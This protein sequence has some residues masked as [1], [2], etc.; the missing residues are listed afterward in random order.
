MPEFGGPTRRTFFFVETS[1]LLAQRETK[2]W[3]SSTRR[4]RSET[5]ESSIKTSPSSEK[6][7][8]PSTLTRAS[9]ILS[10]K[11]LILL[12]KSPNKEAPDKKT[13]L[14][15]VLSI[16]SDK[17]S[18]SFKLILSFKKALFVNSPGAASEKPTFLK[19]SIIKDITPRLP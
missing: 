16:K 18:A 1:F 19:T 15:E 4:P 3:K 9:F 2:E 17:D 13:S 10:E 6:S 7:I 8:S 5:N 11:P 14:D 12:D